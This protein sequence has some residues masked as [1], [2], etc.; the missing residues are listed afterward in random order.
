L[1]ANKI[2]NNQDKLNWVIGGIFA[3]TAIVQLWRI[4]KK[5][6]AVHR[7][8]H[9]EEE[10]HQLEQKIIGMRGSDASK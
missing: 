6:D 9:P 3:V 2:S 10:K 8:G 4:F 5:K 1:I 7:L